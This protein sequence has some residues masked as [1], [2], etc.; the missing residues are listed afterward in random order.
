MDFPIVTPATI[1]D[2]ARELFKKDTGYANKTMKKLDEEICKSLI[3]TTYDTASEAW[4]LI[5]PSETAAL[6]GAKPKHLLWTLLFLNCY[7][8]MPILTRVVG[9]V[10]EETY[11]FWVFLFIEALAG[12]K[13]RVVSGNLIPM[14]SRLFLCSHAIILLL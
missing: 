14:S 3:G 6:Q 10:D 2:H 8:T 7:C 12:M 1:A 5:N 9:G 4:N 11:R 13:P